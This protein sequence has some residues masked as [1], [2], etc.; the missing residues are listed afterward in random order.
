MTPKERLAAAITSKEAVLILGTGV[1]RQASG[2]APSASWTGLLAEGIAFCLA[3]APTEAD[4][5]WAAKVQRDITRAASRSLIAAATD[6]ERALEAP[7]ATAFKRFFKETV[8][9]LPVADPSLPEAIAALHKAGAVL[10]TTNYDDLLKP[11]TNLPTV[12]WQDPDKMQEVFRRQRE[13]I[14]HLHGHW[15]EAPSLVFGERSYDA[16][17]RAK[18]AQ[19]LQT[20]IT[21]LRSLVFIG[22]GDGLADPNTG[23]LLE[24]LRSSTVPSTASFIAILC[25]EKDAAKL[26][27]E[28]RGLPGVEIIPYGNDYPD[29]APFL[30]S[31]LASPSPSSPPSPPGPTLPTRPTRYHGRAILHGRVAT[32]L[33]TGASA[34]LLHGAGGIGKT[35]L[36]HAV[37]HDPEIERHFAQ[38]R[39]HAALDTATSAEAMAIAIIRATGLDPANHRFE[40]ALA[41]MAEAPGLLV[42]D[43][44][45]APFLPK[46]EKAATEALLAHLSQVPGLALLATIRGDELPD[47]PTWQAHPVPPVDDATAFAILHDHAPR[48]A[49]TDP[50]WPAFCHA[51]GGMPL[52]ITLIARRAYT[53]TTLRDLWQEWQ[54]KGTSIAKRLGMEPHRLTSLDRSITLS[55]EHASPPALRLFALL[56]Q[57]PSGLADEDRR[58]L[59]KDDAEDARDD[60]LRLGLAH[61]PPGRIDLLPPIRRYAQAHNRPKEE[62]AAAWPAYYLV[63]VAEEAKRMQSDGAAAFARL[64]PELATLEAAFATANLAAAVT[65][66]WGFGNLVRFR[67]VGSPAPLL[68]LAQRCADADDQAESAN[69]NLAAGY[70]ALDRSD[71][72]TASELFEKA[73]T[74]YRHKGMMDGAAI[75]IANLGDIAARRSDYAIATARLQEALPLF[76]RAGDVLGEANCIRQFGDI[77]MQREEYATAIARY[78]ETR[79]LYRQAADTLGEANC[80]QRLGVIALA[81]S[82]HATATTH[83]DEALPLYRRVG[84][85]LGEANC[86]RSLGNIAL[87]RSDHAIATARFEEA[88]PL[89]R[90]VGDVLGEANCIRS[91]GNIASDQ[92]DT[93]TTRIHYETALTLYRRIPE[94]FSIGWTHLDLANLPDAPDRDAHLAAAR[95]AWLSINRT[96]LIA[97]HLDKPA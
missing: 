9:T 52:A 71:Y 83:F 24:W 85:V 96:D 50:D 49:A 77:A 80:I 27:D 82:D 70:I 87:A 56:G 64:A 76:Q 65:A 46:D 97:E 48:I 4:A 72:N 93:A 44:L 86:I 60:L 5:V 94:P 43:N 11:A 33:R 41:Y 62:D 73:L 32:T 39:W 40:S 53:R 7:H 81:R 19:A 88:L 6:I 15:D 69:C 90:R 75:C 18:H 8:G 57:L 59:L 84:S 89:H 25:R 34:V 63:L 29:L 91:L 17:S 42:L 31:L 3:N 74:I 23:H 58:V 35:T 2:N 22:C 67:G 1:S 36:A 12:T 61:A 21:Q 37:L 95:E 16:I 78:Q 20:A 47:G 68:A 54:S 66:V 14:V 26:T 51:L 13:A 30:R 92:G 45:E 55:V 38:R 28:W 79:P 10:A